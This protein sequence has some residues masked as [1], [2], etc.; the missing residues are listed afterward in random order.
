MRAAFAA[1]GGPRLPIGGHG[2]CRGVRGEQGREA[3]DFSGTL[4]PMQHLPAL[5]GQY[6]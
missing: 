6:G 5:V 1:A 4:P 3:D 2:G